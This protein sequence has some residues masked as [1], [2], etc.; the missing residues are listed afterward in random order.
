MFELFGSLVT[1]PRAIGVQMN[2][3]VRGDVAN[4]SCHVLLAAVA[5]IRKQ[6]H[7]IRFAIDTRAKIVASPRPRSV[8]GRILLW[9]SGHGLLSIRRGPSPTT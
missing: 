1:L 8:H 5:V 2:H 3:I 4:I 6:L 7:F 9:R